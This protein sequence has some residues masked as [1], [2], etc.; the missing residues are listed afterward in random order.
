MPLARIAEIGS[1][2][3]RALDA[4]HS[5]GI[6]HRD[7]KPEN[8]MLRG[9]GFVKV[10]DFGLARSIALEGSDDT[11]THAA[12]DTMPGVVVGTASYMSPERIN[13]VQCGPP[14]MCL[15]SG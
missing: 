14:Q 5:A 13:G 15:R 3:A 11:M 4:A 7:V 12:L 6:V 2:V 10:L 8:V 9:D 1:Q